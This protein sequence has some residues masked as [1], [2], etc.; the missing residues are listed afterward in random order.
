MCGKC[1]VNALVLLR[2]E[3][4]RWSGGGSCVRKVLVWKS[5]HNFQNDAISSG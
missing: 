5:E 2:E 1:R 3:E 4:E